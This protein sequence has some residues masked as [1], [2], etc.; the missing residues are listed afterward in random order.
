MNETNTNETKGAVSLLN[1]PTAIIIAGAIIAVAVIWTKSPSSGGLAENTASLGSLEQ[2]M[3]P[4]SED[5][6]ILG[7]PNAKIKIVEYSDPSCPFCKVFH[8]TMR[9]VM[10]TYGKSGDVAWV[11]RSFPLDKPSADGRILHPNAGK[12]SEAMECAGSLGGNDKFWAY[13]NRFYDITPS[14]TRDAP[15]GLDQKELPKI[16]QYVGLD[17]NDFNSCLS[18]GKF[19]D[20]VEAQ[21]LEGVNIGIQGT[22]S[23]IIVT[24][25]GKYIPLEGAQP[26]ENVK[27]AIDALLAES[28]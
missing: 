20:K 1:I 22:P 3:K 27:Q 7:N 18:S 28:K 11:Y 13:T 12:E 19:K 5:D 6:H 25:S 21:F 10:D 15:N 23:S 8:T 26:Y 24:P 4:V 9:K 16:A 17:V 2:K 14:V